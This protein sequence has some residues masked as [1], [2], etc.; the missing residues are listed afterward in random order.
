MKHAMN[1]S[2]ALPYALL[3]AALAACDGSTKVGEL[4]GDAKRPQLLSVEV[5]RL[6][7]IYAFQRIDPLVGD[8]RL[9][10]NR[11]LELVEA[12][13]IVNA[14]IE[15]QSL[16]D[17]AGNVVA[18]A[19]YEFLPFDKNVGHEQLVVLWDNREG[20]GEENAFRDALTR[21]QT[22]LGA[23]PASYRGQNTQV[24]PIPIVPRNAAVRLRFSSPLDVT[25]DF[26]A[27]NPGAIQLLEFKGDPR[28][29]QPVDAFRIL[30]YRVIPSGDSIILDT[31]ILGGEAG[32][33]VTSPGLP[34]SADNVTANIRIAIPSRGTV[35]PTFYVREDA[36]AEL[37]DVD[38]S[39]RAAVIRDFRSGNLGDG[40]AG[41]LRE[42]E[43]PMI[44][45]S[46]AMGITEVDVANNVVTLNKRLQTVPVRGRY[47]FVDGPLG[48]GGVPL[49]PLSSPL[50]RPLRS[51]DILTQTIQVE[52]RPGVFE[53]VL[54]RAEI[55]ENLEIAT[56]VNQPNLGRALNPPAGDSGQGESLPVVRV[57]VA[58]V[59]AGRD[60]TGELRRFQA[61]ALP[62]GQECVLRA[63]YY[64]SV[65]FSGSAA[66]L[67]DKGWRKLFVRIEP[68]PPQPSAQTLEAQDV[69]PNASISIE[70]TKPMD[71][72]QV[73][74]TSNLLVTS[75][76]TG[77]GANAES[78]A[79]QMTD[80]KKAT[81]RVVPT[82]LSDLAGDG[83][84]LRL[85][86]PMGFFH[87]NGSAEAYS[88][89]VRLGN[90]GVLDLAG[91]P[92]S[93][94]DDPATPSDS[95]SVDFTLAPA[96]ATNNVG[97]HSWL[98]SAEDEDGTL[99]GSV[100]IF[101]QYRLEDGRLVGASGL[102]FGRSADAQNLSTIS[103]ITRGE[104][105]LP[106][107]P[108]Q[109][110]PPPIPAQPA[111][112]LFPV[113]PTDSVGNPHPGLLYWQPRMSD[114]IGPPNVPQVYDYWQQVPQ[115]VGRVVEPLKPQG[116]RMQMRYIEDDF[117]LSYRQ[118]S[119]F[120]LDVEQFYWSP[121][122]DE[123][124]LYDV[125]DRFTMSLAHSRRRPDEFWFINTNVDPPQCTLACESMN[126]A[127]SLLFS[128]N[129]LESTSLVPV[130]ED[131]VYRINPNTA[132][133]TIDNVKYVPF[134]RFDRT[135]TWRDSR[136]V[137][138]DANGNVIGLGG[139]QQPQALPPN[140]DLT[141][142][143]DSP[144][145]TDGLDGLGVVLPS[146]TDFITAGGSVWVEDAADFVGSN[147]RDHDPIAL[148][149]LVD[150]KV[151]PDDAANG[152]ANGN[153]GFQVA[154]LGSP[155]FG[156]P[157]APGGYYD[158]LGSG[159]GTAVPPWPRVRVHASG[160]F[161]LITGAPILIDPANQLT[162]AAS[163]VKDAGLGN[164]AQALF[165][166]PPGDGML[167][168][169]RADFVRKVS[170]MTFGFFDTLQP[171]RAQF[172]DA[173]QTVT[174]DPGFPNLQAVNPN[175]RI[176][177]VVVQIDPPQ[178]RQPAGTSVL[179]EMRGAESFDNA[180]TLY[181]PS[182]PGQNPTD[183]FNLRGNLLNANYACEAYRYSTANV[184]GSPRV[185]AT[186]LTRYVPEDQINLIRDSANGL[187]PR[188]LNMRIV[189]TNNV[190]VTPALSP[191]LR[192]MTIVYRMQPAP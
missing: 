59:F 152:F 159:C 70:F 127:L 167:N 191:A 39:G 178:A 169:A 19:D 15:T 31:T 52:I 170:T 88:V 166:A 71:L 140:G 47:P 190:E 20:I 171:Q 135:Y 82:R 179:V 89:H 151:F 157:G 26:F 156:F 90:A 35:I 187:L 61:N 3:L 75:R 168:W 76:P 49:G 146:Y 63:H 36:I 9:R 119:E 108:A 57:R 4:G 107:Q 132:F 25:S 5:G 142:K 14:S 38:S 37:N 78:F 27:A 174:A 123:T 68:K 154:M 83:T 16:F 23:V 10:G 73:D 96:A 64:D 126:S 185:A 189:M 172:V 51:G 131:K 28:V 175:L 86:P 11:R 77:I 33:G 148:P 176:S 81:A 17:A 62:T 46:L 129:V 138:V 180:G 7:D 192:S 43:A 8:R 160:G 184:A 121:F 55:L 24:R 6:V 113:A 50:Q 2:R 101:G 60:S 124:V 155:S 165:S 115:P 110:G 112:Q 65:P 182:Y 85:Q 130:F 181:N 136:L 153:N 21:A 114:T 139:A 134:P 183:A 1:R 106:A 67:S 34:L 147:Q 143:I 95:W 158:R 103:R 54:L 116:S 141:A 84:V 41:R 53:S 161:D 120:G 56:A 44:V 58:S 144:W 18:T 150:F 162:A 74:Y 48:P 40:P 91:N 93:I 117:S 66:K 97:W 163:I 69:Q 12:N 149:L 125:F 122:N 137:T 30:P 13:V 42:P 164:P 98:F 45:A 133:R 102:R 79:A 32:G 186:N 145:V 109:P 105:W 104:C 177:D 22:G 99:P 100:D 29:V 92:L 118:P 173:N 111:I 94:F 72:D 87:Q 80:P 128:D 188:F